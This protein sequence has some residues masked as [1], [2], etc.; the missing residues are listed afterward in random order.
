[1]SAVS[2]ECQPGLLACLHHA[3]E[4]CAC[5][6]RR[7]TL[8]YRYTLDDLYPMVDALRL[9]A[10]SYN[11]WALAVSDALEA[12]LSKKRSAWPRAGAGGRG[13]ARPGLHWPL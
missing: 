11:E 5:P 2:C 10:E 9:R 3:A 7:H 6:P 13:R 12:K 4:L 8:R 1:M